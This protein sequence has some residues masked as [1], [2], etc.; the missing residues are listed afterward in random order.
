VE[1]D[2]SIGLGH[3]WHPDFISDD[4]ACAELV[5]RAGDPTL[6]PRIHHWNCGRR[7]EAWSGPVI[8]VGDASG[9][10]EPLASLRVQQLILHV[11]WLARVLAESD[12][13]PGDR[14]R[15]AYNRIVSQAWDENRDFHA[16]HYR[17]NTAADTPFWQMV[18]ATAALS[19]Y[20]ELV[21]LY[22]SIGPSSLLAN[23][24]PTWPGLLGIDTWLAAMLGLGVPFRHHPEITAPEKKAWESQ[25]QQRRQLAKQAV[26]AEL[27]IGA[28]RRAARPQPRVTL[29]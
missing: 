11:H 6:T 25:C 22:Q 8:A 3:A 19:D 21:A 1:H 24:L 12:G 18:R 29:P 27:C 7:R 10:V 26:P 20:S 23:S 13:Q 17:F 5:A 15:Q 16:I 2:E 28:A 14:S 4:Q 9:F